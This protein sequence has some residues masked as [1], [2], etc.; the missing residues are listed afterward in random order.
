MG[1]SR[2]Q[3]GRR[4]CTWQ[5]PEPPR[6]D[7]LGDDREGSWPRHLCAWGSLPRAS[8]HPSGRPG[9]A[10]GSPELC[11]PSVGRDW[12]SPVAGTPCAIRPHDR[13]RSENRCF[14]RARIGQSL[15]T[16]RPELTV[17]TSTSCSVR[18]WE[19]GC[20]SRR[21]R[22]HPAEHTSG[23]CTPGTKARPDTGLRR[24]TRFCQIAA[25]PAGWSIVC[26]CCLTTGMEW[27]GCEGDRWPKNTKSLLSGPSQRKSAS[28]R[29]RDT[30]T[31]QN[32]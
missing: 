23:A 18:I 22:F 1:L 8:L 13:V 2:S 25:T 14:Q 24:N 11:L 26:G 7:E 3:A 9:L 5:G 31:W 4:P 15:V 21:G 32:G 20:S 17:W 16:R 28:P 30:K 6:R 10:P 27:R 19:E 29:T 12:I